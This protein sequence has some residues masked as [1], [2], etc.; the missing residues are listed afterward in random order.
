M[1]PFAII[2]IALSMSADAFAAALAKG[3]TLD[4]PPLGEALRCGLI[5]GL[6][7]A[8]TPVIGW[9]LGAAVNTGG[10]LA[11]DRWVAFAV[12]AAIGAKI[13]FG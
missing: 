1:N 2:V 4:R 7:E 10:Y 12:V 5:F 8:I 6:I 11:A 13:L 9:I 3:A